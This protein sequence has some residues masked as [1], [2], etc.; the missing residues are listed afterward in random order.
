MLGGEKEN[1]KSNGVLQEWDSRDGLGLLQCNVMRDLRANSLSFTELY[2]DW[3]GGVV[4]REEKI[5]L[6]EGWETGTR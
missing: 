2:R 1:S 4:A 6:A 3:L 5:V